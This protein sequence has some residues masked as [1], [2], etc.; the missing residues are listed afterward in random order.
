M[1]IEI[2]INGDSVTYH[3]KRTTAPKDYD[4]FGTITVYEY[5]AGPEYK[6]DSFRIVLIRDE[7]LNW[8]TARYASGLHTPSEP[9]ESF[10][11][12]RHVTDILWKRLAQRES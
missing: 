1:K 11:D 4:G 5:D 6:R 7:H 10:V 12:E 9:E 2:K 8:Q 3:V